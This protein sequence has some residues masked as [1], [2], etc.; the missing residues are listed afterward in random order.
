MLKQTSLRVCVVS[1]LGDIQCLAGH[2]NEQ[3]ALV[4]PLVWGVGEDNLQR[5]LPNS[6]ILY[7]NTFI[8]PGTVLIGPMLLCTTSFS[9]F[10]QR[11][12]KSL[13]FDSAF[14]I[15][16]LLWDISES[17]CSLQQFSV[18]Y[19]SCCPRKLIEASQLISVPS[20]CLTRTWKRPKYIL[21]FHIA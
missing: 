9:L 10:R 13:Y 11:Q 21:S 3:H 8:I 18:P 15:T 1:T 19:F 17:S 12:K 20:F 5:S 16:Q 4:D 14:R 2:N 7:S 6:V